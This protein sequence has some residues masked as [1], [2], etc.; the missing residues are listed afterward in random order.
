[1]AERLHPPRALSHAA[2]RR[3]GAE[4]LRTTLDLLYPPNCALCQARIESAAQGRLC[5]GCRQALVEPA[6]ACDRCGAAVT[7]GRATPDGCPRCA[8][9]RLHFDATLRVGPY[10]GPLRTAVLRI[11]RAHERGLAIA[12][13]DALAEACSGRWS[14]LA[15][16]AI[17]PVPMH[18]SRW[19]WR[20]ANSAETLAERLAARYRV[21]LAGHLL[22]RNRRTAPQANLSP[23]RR[24]ANVRGAFRAAAHKDLPGARLLLVD[25]IMTTGAT[26]NEA[27]RALRRAGAVFVGVAVLARAEGSL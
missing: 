17:V 9:Q 24:R 19:L 16:D 20:G 13:G 18:W 1:M 5:D 4:W 8:G 6:A 7:M 2:I 25:D 10:D 23:T 27:A 26:V 21:P 15:P 14:A 12:L 11:K 22:S 3:R